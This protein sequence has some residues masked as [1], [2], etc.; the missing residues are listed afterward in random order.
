MSVPGHVGKNS[1]NV[2]KT[3]LEK[4]TITY[5]YFHVRTN[6]IC[7]I[8]STEVPSYPMTSP[9]TICIPIV[10]QVLLNVVLG[11]KNS[12]D[13]P[14]GHVTQDIVPGR[15]N[16]IQR[17]LSPMTI[18]MGDKIHSNNKIHSNTKIEPQQQ[19]S[20][21]IITAPSGII[22]ALHHLNIGENR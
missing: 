3:Y 10:C 16:T 20:L 19:N 14:T 1:R 21:T 6:Q 17:K 4:H 22:S 8:V 13:S 15:R 7:I 12:W 2:L 18:V 5:A 9:G 11:H